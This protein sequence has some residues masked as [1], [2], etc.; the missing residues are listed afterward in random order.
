MPYKLRLVQVFSNFEEV[1]LKMCLTYDYRYFRDE[2]KCEKKKVQKCNKEPK[3]V[4][5][6]VHKRV[7]TTIE[8]KVAFRVCP[9]Q[10]DHEYSPYERRTIDFTGY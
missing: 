9:G 1:F 2:E 8:G 3:I 4:K 6:E 5:E 10:S 7:P